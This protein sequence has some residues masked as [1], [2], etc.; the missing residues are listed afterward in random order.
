MSDEVFKTLYAEEQIDFKHI[1]KTDL[2]KLSQKI[3]DNINSR[4]GA[5]VAEDVFIQELHYMSRKD[6]S[7][8]R[9]GVP[10]SPLAQVLPRQ[11]ALSRVG[12]ASLRQPRATSFIFRLF[13]S[14]VAN[15][16]SR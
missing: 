14:Q 4:V 13:Q 8:K 5:V 2:A 1:E 15:Q 11:S 7:A 6:V 9:P 3:R 16:A 10:A 12:G